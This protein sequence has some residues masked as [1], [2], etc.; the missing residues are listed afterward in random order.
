M[1]MDCFCMVM[2]NIPLNICASDII[3]IE[4]CIYHYGT[5]TS[6]CR[7]DCAPVFIFILPQYMHAAMNNIS[8]DICIILLRICI[9]LFPPE[10]NPVV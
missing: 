7:P 3:I 1:I 9:I 10:Q 4:K 6:I 5:M 2:D 8:R